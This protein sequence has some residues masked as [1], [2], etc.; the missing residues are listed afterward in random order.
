MMM[1]IDD[2]IMIEKNEEMIQ[3]SIL[4][5]LSGYKQKCSYDL[6]LTS[7]A[8]IYNSNTRNTLSKANSR[9]SIDSLFLKKESKNNSIHLINIADRIE[10][11]KDNFNNALIKLYSY[12]YIDMNNNIK[13]KG[14]FDYHKYKVYNSKVI[15]DY[16]KA[17]YHLGLIFSKQNSEEFLS[18]IF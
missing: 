3:A 1:R 12:N 18:Y 11:I 15:M 16:L 9:S 8:M 6:L 7:I 13:L 4:S 2:L 5:F 17:S 14:D 10:I